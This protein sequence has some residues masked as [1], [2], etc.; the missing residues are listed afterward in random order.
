[1]RNHWRGFG[2][3]DAEEV[4]ETITAFNL[5]RIIVTGLDM[6]GRF[7]A[8]AA[9]VTQGARLAHVTRSPDAN[10]PLESVSPRDWRTLIGALHFGR[11]PA[12][13]SLP[14]ATARSVLPS[15]SLWLAA[16]A[17]FAGPLDLLMRCAPQLTARAVRSDSVRTPAGKR[18][19]PFSLGAGRRDCRPE[20][21]A[22][23]PDHEQKAAADGDIAGED[24]EF[25]Q[26]RR[27]IGD[28]PEIVQADGRR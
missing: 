23:Q 13:P 7:G 24:F 19:A 8:L 21:P 17:C 25:R 27:R 10:A 20:R 5:S 9:A 11:W 14:L 2:A 16:F 4:S 12:L 6:A 1:M 3:G 15:C 26:P 22:T 18:L 28:M